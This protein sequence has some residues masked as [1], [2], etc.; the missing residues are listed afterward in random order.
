MGETT[1]N[2]LPVEQ[3]RKVVD[4]IKAAMAEAGYPL[5]IVS[6]RD[7]YPCYVGGS[8]PLDVAWRAGALVAPLF[9]R[10]AACFPCWRIYRT[11]ECDHD[12]WDNAPPV[13]RPEPSRG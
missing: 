8:V 12:T 1:R 7:G 9:G 3:H 11:P 5:A 6:I 13:V 10:E 2:P 4:T